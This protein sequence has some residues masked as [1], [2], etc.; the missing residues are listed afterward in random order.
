[1]KTQMAEYSEIYQTAV[2]RITASYASCSV[3]EQK[4]MKQILQ[5]M[6]KTGYSYTLEKVWL[7]DFKE[8]PVGIDQFLDDPYYL[9]QTNNYGKTVYP[10]WRRMMKDVFAAGN[11]YS[12]IILSGATRIG[13]SS[14]SVTMVAYMLYRLMLYRDPHQYFQKKS[15]SKFT[16]GFANLTKEL[17]LSVAYREFNDTLREVPWFMDRGS[18]TRS[19]R[20]FFYI[21]DGGKIEIIAAS[22]GSQLLGKQLWTCLVGDTLID[23]SK[24]PV[25]IDQL[26]DNDEVA[27]SQYEGVPCTAPAKLTK[28]VDETI[29][30]WISATAY[31]EG[32]PDHL[33]MLSDGSYKALGDLTLNDDLMELG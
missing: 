10:F 22:D 16:I 11:R 8:I 12:E 5:E 7:N 14:T 29:R 19:D 28:Y 1:V 3:A 32:T 26:I 9:G 15:I 27:I 21:P 13:K 6:A 24:G 20:N 18:V 4:L 33:V 23:T 2:D 17:A 25:P 31:I 30:V